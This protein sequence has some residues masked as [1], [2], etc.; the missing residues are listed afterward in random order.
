[1]RPKILWKIR[2]ADVPVG[3][4]V[5]YAHYKTP[6]EVIGRQEGKHPVTIIINRYGSIRLTG[7]FYLFSE[8][9]PYEWTQ[10]QNTAAI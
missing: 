2:H 10:Q 6:F 5:W 4:S 3:A 9:L 7:D 8:K 1:M